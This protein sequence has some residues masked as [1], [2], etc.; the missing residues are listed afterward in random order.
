[1]TQFDAFATSYEA[2]VEEST[3]FSGLPHAFFMAAKADVIRAVIARRLPH[4]PEPAAL[5]VGCGIG[6]LHPFVRTLFPRLCGVDVSERSIEQAARQN[7]GVE[8]RSYA[9]EA[10]PYPDEEFD[11][12]L[13]VCVMH[14]VPLADRLALVGQM[15]RVLRPGGLGCVIEH[16]PFNPLTRLSVMRCPFDRDARLLTAGNTRRLMAA[17]GFDAIETG[18]FLLLPSERP[19]PRRL[20]RWLARAPLGAQYMSCGRK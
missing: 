15:R 20:E 12:T 18:F 2:A 5:D 1:M 4:V 9:G 3:D 8:Y 14:H 17:A 11:L 19:L 7:P 13:A 16:N 6:S 10:L